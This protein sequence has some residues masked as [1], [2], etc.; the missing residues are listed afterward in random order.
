MTLLCPS[1]N[2]LVNRPRLCQ[3]RPRMTRPRILSL[4]TANPPYS[5]H[6]EAVIAKAREQLSPFI[7]NFDDYANVYRRTQIEHRYSATPLAW[8][9]HQHTWESRQKAYL[10]GVLP[11]A[12]DA[13]TDCTQAIDLPLNQ[14]HH[15]IVVSTTGVSTPSVDALISER[16]GLP[17]SMTRIPLFGWGCAGGVLGMNFA[18]QWAQAHPGENVLLLVTEMCTTNFQLEDLEIRNIVATALFGDGTAAAI[19]NT[20]GKG[21]VWRGGLEHQWPQTL[22]LMG[23]EVTNKGLGVVLSREIPTVIGERFAP[24]MRDFLQREQ[25]DPGQLREAIL[26]PGGAKILKLLEGILPEQLTP[27]SDVWEVLRNYGNMSAPT[28][29]FVLKRILERE[30][31]P[32]GLGLMAAFGPG[33]KA[34][35]GLLDFGHD[36]N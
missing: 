32:E 30:R 31:Q 13:I 4:A 5:L 6:Q 19:L 22:D 21:P 24:V 14:I 35:L 12:E 27:A 26:H 36:T 3:A 11:T 15:L 16:M 7:S 18:A 1:G 25:V 9:E 8:Y 17:P 23:W 34:A 20:E 29:L 28:V 10:E 33:F 2:H